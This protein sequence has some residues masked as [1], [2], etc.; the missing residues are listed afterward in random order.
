M[1]AQNTTAMWPRNARCGVTLTVNFDAESFDLHETT[2]DNLYGK[3]SYGRYGMRA[4]IWRLLDLL[5]VQGVKATFFVPALDAENNRAAIETILKDGHEIAARGY[6]F[7]DHAK[8]GDKERETLQRAHEALKKVTG[9]APLGWRA[10]FGALSAET[11]KLL[12]GM[13]YLYD[14]SFQDDDLPYVLDLKAGAPLVELPTSQALDDS[15]YY[16]P[17][18]SHIRVLKTWKEEFDAIYGEGL[19]LNLVVH[20]RGDHGSGRAARAR[21]V[22]DFIT[23]VARHPGTEFFTCGELAQ[24]WK[25]HHPQAEL[26]PA[27]Q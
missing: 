8:L 4:G 20:P 19:Y 9:Q 3:F 21:A 24:W 15:S 1:T 18:H 22:D 12:A 7:E 13:G 26:L 2:P 16:A 27:Y 6:A 25:Q 5:R 14:S 23:Y 11:L 10:P 17:R